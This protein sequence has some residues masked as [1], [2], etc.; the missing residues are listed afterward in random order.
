MKNDPADKYF[1][2]YI[3]LRDKKCMRCFSPVRFNSRGLPVSHQASHFQSRRKEATRFEPMNVDTLCENCHRHLT[4]HPREHYEWQVREK[5]QRVVDEVITFSNIYKKK[6]RKAEAKF[7]RD[8]VKRIT[9]V[10]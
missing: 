4:A 10:R 1:S 6:D 9:G 7:W 3:R 8:E 5:G 2:I